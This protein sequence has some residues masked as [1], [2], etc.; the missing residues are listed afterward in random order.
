MRRIVPIQRACPGVGGSRRRGFTVIE[1]MVVLAVLAVL[2][3]LSLSWFRDMIQAQ[4]LR[5]T[6]NDF[7]AAI[8][9][10]RSE[11]IARGRRVMMTPLASAPADWRQGWV[12]FV[13]RNANQRPDA[14]D[15]VIFQRGEVAYGLTIVSA[16][17]SGQASQYI[18]YNMAGRSCGAGNSMTA[19]Y[20]SVSLALGRHAR[21]IKIN[22]LGRARICDPVAHP[23]NCSGVASDD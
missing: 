12:V 5:S 2:L 16:F 13:D 14:G 23:G 8:A 11:A 22:M 18:A 17:S 10:T 1:L 3:G 19:H 7:F 6:A 4:Q 15:E 20:G 9:L 21:N